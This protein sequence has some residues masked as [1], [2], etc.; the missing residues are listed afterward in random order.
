MDFNIA[1]QHQKIV[2]LSQSPTFEVVLIVGARSTGKTTDVCASLILKLISNIQKYSKEK[3]NPTILLMRQNGGSIKGSI[4]RAF[5]NKLSE[6]LELFE[7]QQYCEI[8]ETAIKNKINGKQDWVSLK[9]FKTSTK[10][11]TS[12]LKGFENISDYVIEEA[13]E[14]SEE[15][16]DQLQNTAIRQKAKIYLIFNTPHKNHWLVKRFFNLIPTNFDGFYEFELK[17]A[18]NVSLIK[19]SM[20]K[21]PFLDKETKNLYQEIGQKDSGRYNLDKYLT[22]VLGLVSSNI[23]GQIFSNYQICSNS[24]YDSV[25]AEE[26]LGLDF[27]FSNDP[28]ALIG[29]KKKNGCLYVKEYIYQNNLTVSDTIKLFEKYGISKK[30]KIIADSGGLGGMLIEEFRRANYNIQPAKKGKDSIKKG[31]LDIKEY[32]VLITESS[33]NILNEFNVYR[34]TLDSNKEI[35]TEPIDAFNH[36]IDAIRYVI[37]EQIIT[38]IEDFFRQKELEARNYFDS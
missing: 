24:A 15:D 10:T 3:K 27:G 13:D 17:K 37:A 38:N 22:D 28:T 9:G 20:L 26:K 30:Q 21:N 29:V 33:Q 34:Y 5:L 35:S 1:L 11:D 19:S 12:N 31:I 25:D 18:K 8:Q 14:I 6:L 36:A 7:I 23:K 2:K 32:L 4:W 16:F